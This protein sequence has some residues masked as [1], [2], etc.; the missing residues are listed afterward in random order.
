MGSHHSYQKFM[1][2]LQLEDLFKIDD[3]TYMDPI[4]RKLY[5]EDLQPKK[6][7]KITG[8]SNPLIIDVN[9]NGILTFRVE[10]VVKNYG[11]KLYISINQEKMK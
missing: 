8:I 7:F 6:T 9:H 11:R 10:D 2:E 3:K 5:N 4:T 1:N